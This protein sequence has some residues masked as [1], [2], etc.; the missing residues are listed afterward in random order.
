MKYFFWLIL[1]DCL[2]WR[3]IKDNNIYLGLYSEN[4]RKLLGIIDNLYGDFESG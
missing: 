4:I 3:L 2:L 1:Y